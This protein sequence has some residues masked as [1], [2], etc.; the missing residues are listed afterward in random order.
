MPSAKNS[1]ETSGLRRPIPASIR[2]TS[3]AVSV[4]STVRLPVARRAWPKTGIRISGRL[5]T[6]RIARSGRLEITHMG[7]QPLSWFTITT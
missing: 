6:K 5:T 7:S 4:R 2:R 3:P 1:S